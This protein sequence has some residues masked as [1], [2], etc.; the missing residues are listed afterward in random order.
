MSLLKKNIPWYG[1]A[2][3]GVMGHSTRVQSLWKSCGFLERDKR[4]SQTFLTVHSFA[5][6]KNQTVRAN[7][8]VL[9]RL[10]MHLC[11][12]LQARRFVVASLP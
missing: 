9:H 4:R 11:S 6:L 5:F 3:L 2:L 8:R 10:T 7:L 1:A 12:Q